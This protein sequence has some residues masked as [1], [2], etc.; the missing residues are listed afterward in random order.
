MLSLIM[1]V[2]RDSERSNV[3]KITV[4][5]KHISQDIV[6]DIDK[7][8][9]RLGANIVLGLV[10]LPSRGPLDL[11]HLRSETTRMR[12]NSYDPGFG[13]QQPDRFW[14][15]QDGGDRGGP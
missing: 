5:A 12:R 8:T 6:M 15:I 3:S 9:D 7:I 11:L 4:S 2:C 14:Y 10:D 1:Y 13:I